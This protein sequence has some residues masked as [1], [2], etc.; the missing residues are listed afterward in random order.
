VVAEQAPTRADHEPDERPDRVAEG[1]E[2]D[3]PV[4]AQ[5][6]K[7]AD[8]QPSGGVD[9][10]EHADDVHAVE[11]VE[12]EVEMDRARGGDEQCQSDASV[13]RHPQR[14]RIAARCGLA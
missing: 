12:V 14:I 10:E 2:Q 1:G 9:E 11:V 8:Q 6:Q 7:R 4:A 13:L 5:E 3:E